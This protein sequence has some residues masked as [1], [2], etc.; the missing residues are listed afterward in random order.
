MISTAVVSS[1]NGYCRPSCEVPAFLLPSRL[2]S[3]RQSLSER[4]VHSGLSSD[5]VI[6][7]SQYSKDRDH[8]QP[9]TLSKSDTSGISDD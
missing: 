1:L 8:G 4:D 6:P 3:T 9:E 7:C 5:A 2:L